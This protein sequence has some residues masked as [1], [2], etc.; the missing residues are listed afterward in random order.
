MAN[1]STNKIVIGDTKVFSL[2]ANVETT[3]VFPNFIQ[4]F[5]LTSLSSS[6]TAIL[7]FRTDDQISSVGETGSNRITFELPSLNVILNRAIHE[8]SLISN[9]AIEIQI[10][11]LR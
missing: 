6:P 4:N 8:L 2:S 5:N 1:P 9:E 7:Y 11:N 3:L 10:A